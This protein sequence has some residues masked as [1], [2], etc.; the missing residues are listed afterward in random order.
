MPL[1][2]ETQQNKPYLRNSR[3]IIK[4][5]LVLYTG[6]PFFKKG[7]LTSQYGIQLTY[8]R[9]R[10]QLTFMKGEIKVLLFPNYTLYSQ[11]QFEKLIGNN[12]VEENNNTFVTSGG[13]N[14]CEIGWI[15]GIWILY[16]KCYHWLICRRLKMF[17]AHFWRSVGVAKNKTAIQKKMQG[18]DKT[19]NCILRWDS[20]S[21]ALGYVKYTF[22]PVTSKYTLTRSHSIFSSPI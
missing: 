20:A 9:P 22:I 7:R 1:N 16:R 8:S 5:N 10:W 11:R 2:K 21:G 15:C 12:G 6:I 19:L 17:Y 3:F 18:L 4:C 14:G 13:N